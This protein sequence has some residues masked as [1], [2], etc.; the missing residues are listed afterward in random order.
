[1][2]SAASPLLIA[3]LPSQGL[4]AASVHETAGNSTKLQ[5]ARSRSSG[6][7]PD[8]IPVSACEFTQGGDCRPTVRPLH[9]PVRGVGGCTCQV[10]ESSAR[11][12]RCT[13]RKATV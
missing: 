4:S 9:R 11:R 12:I 2:V 10:V 3:S 1:M 7:R 5:V 13:L 8:A 6:N